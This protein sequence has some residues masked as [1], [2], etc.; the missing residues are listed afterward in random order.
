MT[1]ILI[2][3]A[4]VVA[5]VGVDDVGVV[6]DG[7]VFSSV[8]APGVIEDAAEDVCRRCRRRYWA[9]RKTWRK[10]NW[11]WMLNDDLSLLHQ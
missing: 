11:S 1:W 5:V 7:S 10:R 4:V 6:V 2:R 8:H 3:D 9:N